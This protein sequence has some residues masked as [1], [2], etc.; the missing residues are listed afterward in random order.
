M[1]EA[2]PVVLG[3]EGGS[4]ALQ[5]LRVLFLPKNSRTAY[6][7]KLLA[8]ARRDL[9]WDVQIVGPEFERRVWQGFVARR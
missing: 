4:P 5:N 1:S 7:R 8:T 9:N 2:M 3:R 6:F